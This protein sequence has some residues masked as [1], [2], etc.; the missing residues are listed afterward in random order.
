MRGYDRAAAELRSALPPNPEI[1][2]FIRFATLAANGHNVQPWRFAV[3]GGRTSI[4]P[5]L[6]RR[7]A[8][9]DPDDHH[10]YASLGCAAE[11]FLIAAAASGRPGA[12]DIATGGD[13][14][15]DIDLARGARQENALFDAIRERQSTRSDFDGRLVPRDDIRQLVNAARID[16][17]AVEI[18]T[19]DED[20][21]AILDH[22]IAGNSAQ[23]DDPAFV[24]ELRDSIRF[25]AA[26]AL[27]ARDGL[28]SA[29]SGNLTMSGWLGRRLFA[30]LYRKSAEN[31]RYASQLRTSAGVAVFVGER[32]DIASWIDVGRSFQRFAL[33][34][35][36]LRIR[37][38]HINQPVEVPSVRADFAQW[39]GNRDA[40]PDLVIR[41]GYA[42]PLPMSLRRPVA[43]VLIADTA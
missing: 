43:D 17:V 14:R 24:R 1:L 11:N 23:M 5:D 15:I 20:R 3:R 2:D 18:F 22:V 28:F 19:S 42:P 16:G 38:S 10:L 35:T 37:H 30:M 7:T 29:C 8:A 4:L 25:N 40:R 6:G 36:A 9:V 33:Q 27:Y 13:G 31:D 21:E 39:L 34:A 41:F 32:P 12:M 26:E